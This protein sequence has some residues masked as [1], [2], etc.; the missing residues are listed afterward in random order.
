MFCEWVV[1]ELLEVA[2]SIAND[3]TPPESLIQPRVPATLYEEVPLENKNWKSSVIFNLEGKLDGN[4][5]GYGPSRQCGTP[6]KL[7]TFHDG[8]G[9]NSPGRWDPEFRRLPTTAN[10]MEIRATIW[11]KLVEHC[12]APL[13]IQRLC[14]KMTKVPEDPFGTDLT[15]SI[16]TELAN[17]CA[18]NGSAWSVEELLTIADGQPFPLK[19]IHEILRLAEDADHEFL[20]QAEIGLPVGVLNKLPRTPAVYE[21]QT[22]WNLFDDP[23]ISSTPWTELFQR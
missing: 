18:K 23:F 5:G 6:G 10:W 22:S 13:G 11:T 15:Q 7:N 20:L 8:F 14:F 1:D 9:L 12:I 19:L 4:I 16:R 21:E 3:G 17:W 2:R